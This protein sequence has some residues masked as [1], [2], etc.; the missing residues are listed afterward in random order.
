[1]I[2]SEKI[3]QIHVAFHNFGIDRAVV[4]FHVGDERFHY[5]RISD[6]KFMFYLDKAIPLA[7]E[8][9]E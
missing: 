1:M 8:L 2:P 4:D 9:E 3:A 5:L 7:Y 6:T